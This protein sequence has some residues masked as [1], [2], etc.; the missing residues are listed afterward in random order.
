MQA[1]RLARR[2]G[3]AAL[4][5]AALLAAPLRAEASWLSA[6]EGLF[7]K[8]P[9]QGA[10]SVTPEAQ[11]E[12]QDLVASLWAR[13]RPGLEEKIKS[14]I[15]AQSGQRH[16]KVLVERL[17]LTKIDLSSP[18][19]I[20]VR[21]I[22]DGQRRVL[23][24]VLGQPHYAGEQ[25]VLEAPGD[26]RGWSLV[27]DGSVAYDFSL[28][29]LKKTIRTDATVTASKLRVTEKIDIDTATDPA[30][31]V[32][33]KVER[34]DADFSLKVRTHR[35]VADALLVV[36][37][38]VIHLVLSHEIGKAL[39]GL[40]PLLGQ[41]PGNPGKP[42]GQGGPAFTPFGQTPD[43][44]KASVEASAAIQKDHAPWGMVFDADFDDP[45]YGRGNLTGWDNLG[46]SPLFTGTYVLGE[47]LRYSATKDPLAVTAVQRACDA[48]KLLLDVQDPRAGRLSRF[49]IP[50][51][52][53]FS[54]TLLP[55][56][57]HMWIATVNGEQYVCLED[58]SRDQHVGT[59]MG[60]SQAHDSID[61]P[62]VRAGSKEVIQRIVDFLESTGWNALR[63]D[64]SVSAP[65]VQS[66]VMIV[67]FTAAAERTD[68][69]KY[70]AIRAKRGR[71]AGFDWINAFMGTL[72]PFFEYFKWNLGHAAY[73]TALRLETDTDRHRRLERGFAVMRRECAHYR[74]AWFD[75]VEAC[76][77]PAARARFG[78]VIQDDLR[79]ASTRSPR[80]HDVRSSADTTI[81]QGTYKA[82]V[83]LNQPIDL[84][85]GLGGGGGPTG[86][87]STPPI[88]IAK[89][90]IPVEKRVCD[91]WF[92]GRASFEL[93]RDGDPHR[94]R[95]GTHLLTPY[96]MG[97]ANG[98]VR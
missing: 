71:I 50:L 19:R 72:D 40:D 79:R 36:L 15:A 56:G 86:N 75:G 44:E 29:G 95:P 27:V 67:A 13:L 30:R 97:R 62:K 12:L 2:E 32:F 94:Q 18:P 93:D 53:P 43:L 10:L 37:K 26:E 34:P 5:L 16:G 23:V 9:V 14:A 7:K 47:A 1:R 77:D 74:N 33:K 41:F 45:T 87:L 64:D 20:S 68:P 61:D 90:P 35:F 49:A 80:D 31:P 60:L 73:Y 82:P 78:P 85:I 46:D 88:V 65:F 38:P 70:A 52:H 48:F 98:Y 4:L 63:R 3:A 81:E 91:C 28:F 96:W 92:W 51:S 83:A 17:A 57:D 58:I 39:K 8:K 54:K 22:D 55:P 6:L 42:W 59:I 11:A 24:F 21:S 69:A 76:V 25:V 66:P 84:G 89:Y